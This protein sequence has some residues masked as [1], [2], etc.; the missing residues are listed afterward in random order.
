LFYIPNSFTPDG[1]EHNNEFKWTFTSGFDPTDFHITIF[2]RWGEVIYE[3][4]NSNDYW[5]GTYNNNMCPEGSYTY[6]V[7]FGSKENDGEYV[8][9]GSLNLIK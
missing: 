6:K 3:S 2:N 1:N 7:N 4:F 8:I 9:T 5:D